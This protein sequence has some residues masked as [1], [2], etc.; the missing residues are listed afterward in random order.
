MKRTFDLL[1]AIILIII[2]IVPMFIVVI[3]IKLSSNGPVFFSSNRV[4]K[5]NRHFKMFKFRSMKL[6]TP[7]VGT[8]L[9]EDPKKALTPIG[10][11]L[12]QWSIDELPQIWNI[13][14]GDMSF[15]GPRPALYNQ[16]DLIALR[17]EKSIDS[18]VP[19]LTGWAQ[20]NGRDELSIYDKVSY[21]QE[22]MLRQSFNF[23]L[24]ILWLT[25]LKVIHKESISH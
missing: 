16:A 24:K 22:Y 15:V 11:Y 2:L 6:G 1:L 25:Y 23:D 7:I 21:D 3:V 10:R 17:T 5:G 9:L 13:L 20:I 19:G 12:R 18:M 4:G 14:Q 8:H